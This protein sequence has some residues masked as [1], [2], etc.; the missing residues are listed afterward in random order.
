[1]YYKEE[2]LNPLYLL[3]AA[4]IGNTLGS[5]VNFFLGFYASNWAMQKNYINPLH[6]EKSKKYFDKYG[7][8]ALLL[9][10]TPF[11]GDPITFV[12]GVLRYSFLQFLIFVTISKTLRYIFLIFIYNKFF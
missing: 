2:G 6:V 5:V 4:S 12:A 10:W 11:I 1:M 7:S 9:S 8:F 3:I